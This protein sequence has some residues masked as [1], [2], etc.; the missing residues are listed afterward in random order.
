MDTGFK[1]ILCIQTKYKSNT[2]EDPGSKLVRTELIYKEVLTIAACRRI[3]WRTAWSGP[4]W[5]SG[6]CTP[7]L[8]FNLIWIPRHSIRDNID[9]LI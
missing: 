9:N 6:S 8:F 2:L 1:G 3:C 7:T 4:V 5:S